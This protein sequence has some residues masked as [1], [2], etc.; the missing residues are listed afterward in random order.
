MYEN[1]YFWR[2]NLSFKVTDVTVS[3]KKS[4]LSILVKLLFEMDRAEG[5][6]IKYALA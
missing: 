1:V 3:E 2:V 4:E 6:S 5:I